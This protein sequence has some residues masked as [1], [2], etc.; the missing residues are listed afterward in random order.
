MLLPCGAQPP[1]RDGMRERVVTCLKCPPHSATSGRGGGGWCSLHSPSAQPLPGWTLQS[2]VLMRE[3]GTCFLLCAW[4]SLGVPV[5]GDRGG[6]GWLRAC[7][8]YGHR[9]GQGLGCGCPSSA[10][11][12]G[13]QPHP[14][15]MVTAHPLRVPSPAVVTSGLLLS[16]LPCHRGSAPSP[17]PPLALPQGSH[18]ELAMVTVPRARAWGFHLLQ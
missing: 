9:A 10:D 12:L 6:E 3:A 17:P 2:E 15:R 4:L 1:S 5:L 18:G 8:G 13:L 7:R 11:R 14:G 16:G